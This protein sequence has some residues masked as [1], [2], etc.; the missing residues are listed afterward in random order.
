MTSAN[1]PR[2]DS[3]AIPSVSRGR[4]VWYDL[5]TTDVTAAT[6]FYTK[7]AGWGTQEFDQGP[8]RKYQMWTAG[9][10]PIGGALLLTSDTASPGTPPHWL[11]SVAVPSVDDTIRQA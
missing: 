1:T 9:G 3:A 4:F 8:D 6:A 7:V 5:M 10:V 11:A 2:A